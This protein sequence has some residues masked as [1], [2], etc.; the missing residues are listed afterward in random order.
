MA[1]LFFPLAPFFDPYDGMVNSRHA[2]VYALAYWLC[3][4]FVALGI[5]RKRINPA[6]PAALLLVSTC[7]AS[8]VYSVFFV[9]HGPVE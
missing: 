9:Y 8:A 5:G 3:L 1:T 2:F 7:V 4:Y 6:I